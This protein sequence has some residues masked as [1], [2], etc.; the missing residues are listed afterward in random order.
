MRRATVNPRAHFFLAFLVSAMV[1]RISGIST[2][3]STHA[4]FHVPLVCH[5][6]YIERDAPESSRVW[7]QDCAL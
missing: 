7:L 6:A 3:E 4:E 1:R 2:A 5:P